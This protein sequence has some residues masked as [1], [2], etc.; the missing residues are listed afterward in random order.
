MLNS[1]NTSQIYRSGTWKRR[2]SKTNIKT[3]RSKVKYNQCQSR[4]MASKLY[5]GEGEK[6]ELNSQNRDS[7]TEWKSTVMHWILSLLDFCVEVLT[8]I[9]TIFGYK[10]LRRYLRSNE[11]KRGSINIFKAFH[12]PKSRIYI[13]WRAHIIEIFPEEATC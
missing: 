10:I 4:V 9:K 8:S 5:C 6:W 12:S 1:L 2:Q 11:V 3:T 7:R 13:I